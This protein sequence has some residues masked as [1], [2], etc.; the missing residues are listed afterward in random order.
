MAEFE[1]GEGD[2]FLQIAQIYAD[3]VLRGTF[4]GDEILRIRSG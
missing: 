1:M 3:F 2:F 4:T